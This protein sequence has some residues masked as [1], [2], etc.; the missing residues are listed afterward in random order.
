MATTN[1]TDFTDD[2]IRAHAVNKGWVDSNNVVRTPEAANSIYD[3]AKANNISAERL[4]SVFGWSDPKNNANSWIAAN[5]KAPLG[6]APATTSPATTTPEATQQTGGATSQG[7]NPATAGGT[8]QRNDGP[9]VNNPWAPGGAFN[10]LPA[11]SAPP[12]A[13]PAENRWDSIINTLSQQNQALLDRLNAPLKPAAQVT[14][15]ESKGVAGRTASIADNP[16]SALMRQSATQ[17]RREAASRGVLNSSAGVRAAQDAMIGKAADIAAAD[18]SLYNQVQLENMR[19]SNAWE[20]QGLDRT[21]QQLVAGQNNA[22]NYARLG[23]EGEQF[24]RKLSSDERMFDRK[25]A[26][27][28]SQFGRRLTEDARQADMTN[29]RELRIADMNFNIQ[30]RR[31]SQD[32]RQFLATMGLEQRKLDTQIDQFAKQ[33]GLS[34]QELQLNRDRLSADDRRFYDDLQMRRDQLAQQQRQFTTEWENRFSLEKMSNANKVDLAKLDGDIRRDLIGVEAAY[35]KDIASNEN[36][37]QA[38]GT[39]MQ[40]IGRIQNNPEL[41]EAAKKTLIDNNIDSFR[42][43]TGFWKKVSGGNVDVSDLL[44]FGPAAGT[45]SGTGTTGGRGGNPANNDPPGGE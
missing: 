8:L 22:L 23:Q 32:D 4:N 17:G 39:M 9:A 33:F 41:D 14:F 15:D 29:T 1:P 10:P 24:D 37:S 3:A 36:I 34:T 44:S 2:Q 12:P 30:D 27:D 19:Q 43:F 16:D 45:G 6:A 35:K 5:K 13:A 26:S 40:E 31:L 28:E 20:S 25:L 42:S 21:L 18:A 11:A 38:W 7:T